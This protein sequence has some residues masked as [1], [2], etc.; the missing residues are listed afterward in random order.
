MHILLPP[1]E[2]KRAG[3]GGAPVEWGAGAL[4]AH[5]R[6]VAKAVKRL[7][8]ADAE[9]AAVALRLPAAGR[10]ETLAANRVLDRSPT[11]A[12]LDRYDGVLYR[13]LDVGSLSPRAR[14]VAEE[15]VVVFS[16]LLGAVGGDEGV[17]WYRVP[18]AAVV[19]PIGA[20]DR[21]WRAPLAKHLAARMEGDLVIDLRSTDYLAMWPNPPGAVRVRILTDVGGVARPISFAGKH[22]KGLLTRALIERPARGVDQVV[23]AGRRLGWRAEVHS[24]DGGRCALDLI[25]P[26]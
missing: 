17:P 24:L 20:L 7:V 13:A 22:G 2:A 6:R 9:G 23:D 19:P 12:A 14:R 10:P 11:M 21:S 4:G 25:M 16:G 18:A 3:G 15:G 26:G 5:R 1:S 8:R